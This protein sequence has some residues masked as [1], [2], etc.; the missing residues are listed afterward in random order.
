MITLF[1]LAF[2][3]SHVLHTIQRVNRSVFSGVALYETEAGIEIHQQSEEK[4][5][6]TD[7]DD[8]NNN[9]DDEAKPEK[10]EENNS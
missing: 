4:Q 1:S 6:C 5:K 3:N 9:I 2:G 7:N 8:N 10:E